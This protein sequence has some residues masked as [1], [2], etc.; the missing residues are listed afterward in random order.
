MSKT[1]VMIA[2]DHA[3]LSEGLKTL[4]EVSENIEV[5]GSA[6]T[7]K[8]AIDLITEL[9]P[10]VV[11]MDI[12]MPVMDGIDATKEILKIAPESK[13]IFLSADVRVKEEAMRSGAL[14][15]LQKPASIDAITRMVCKALN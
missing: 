1:K 2:D 7:G 11:L 6:S 12:S 5:V 9:S 3:I 10:D 4:L 15:F 8:E 14:A 13:I